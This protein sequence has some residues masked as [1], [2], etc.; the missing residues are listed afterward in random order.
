MSDI[1]PKW[2]N[3]LPMIIGVAAAVVGTTA[4]AGVW[5]YFTPKYTRVGYQPKQPVA[6]SHDIHATQLGIDCR[7]CHNSVE[8]SWFSNIPATTTCMNCHSLVVKDSPKLEP[9]RESYRTGKPIPW[10][11][12]H[13]VPDYVY[14]NHSV[15]VNRGIS[16]VECHGPVNHMDEVKHAKPL[17]MAF[18]VEC[19][20]DPQSR[21]RPNELVTQLDWKGTVDGQKLVHDWKVQ[22]GQSCSTCHR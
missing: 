13:K 8:R 22:P 14:F 5:Y 7:Y 2:T 11:Q 12:I 6:F 15:H 4:L 21:I 1:F 17:S 10:V 19:H 3:R 18:C 9:V 20:R 16:C